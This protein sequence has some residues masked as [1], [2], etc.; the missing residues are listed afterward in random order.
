[1]SSNYNSAAAA[2]EVLVDDG[3]WALV[4]PRE[5]VDDLFAPSE[6]P[7]T[8]EWRAAGH[9]QHP[10]G[11][12]IIDFGS[13]FTQLIARRVREAHVYCEIHP[14]PATMEWIREWKP[15]GI[16]L[17][18]GPN[19]V[20]GDDVPTRRAGAARARHSDPRPLLRH[21]AAGPP[22][23]RQGRSGRPSANT[24]GPTITVEGGRL[25]RVSRQGED[26]PVWMSHG[27][28][29]DTPP[30]G[31][32]LTGVE[33]QLPRSPA[34]EH[35][36]QPLYGVQFHPEVAHTPRGGEICCTTSCS[37]SATAARTGRRGISSR[38]RSRGSGSWSGRDGG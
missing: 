5:A 25:F 28:H 13:Q 26:D 16:I 21:A 30:P 4:R 7:A 23:G 3:R 1:M 18:G 14:P 11:I 10:D 22:V 35:T 37:R 33:R 8:P 29:V 31:F 19:S 32:A 38:A 2:A 9:D 12:L 34:I 15:K 17:S 6:T 36:S 27:D 24:A 20:Y